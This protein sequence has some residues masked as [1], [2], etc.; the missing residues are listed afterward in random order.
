MITIVSL[1]KAA[2]T[3]LLHVIFLLNIKWTSFRGTN[4]TQ[5]GDARI[6]ILPFF[7]PILFFLED[8]LRDAAFVIDDFN[9]CN[10][11]NFMFILKFFSCRM[12]SAPYENSRYP[13]MPKH[14]AIMNKRTGKILKLPSAK[15]MPWVS[16]WEK[17]YKNVN[18]VSKTELTCTTRNIISDAVWTA[19]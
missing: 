7:F 5:S 8:L 11:G 15:S 13:W 3:S 16:V 10:D 19:V 17:P 6:L 4:Y 2:V 18:K 12:L 14:S 1:P 9:D